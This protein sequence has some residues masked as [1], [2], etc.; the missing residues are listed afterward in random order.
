M[1]A[2]YRSLLIVLVFYPY[3][4]LSFGSEPL[5]IGGVRYIST[6]LNHTGQVSTHDF[7]GCMRNFTIN[8]EDMLRRDSSSQAFVQNTCPRT[9]AGDVCS[10][11]RCENG[12][13]CVKQ[14]AEPVC[15]CTPQYMGPNCQ[16]GWFILVVEM[17]DNKKGA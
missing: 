11:Y 10:G 1:A 14:W 2:F 4:S 3:R 16:T 5:L 15:Y 9:S 12:G 13:I 8:T 6:I 17:T 7:I